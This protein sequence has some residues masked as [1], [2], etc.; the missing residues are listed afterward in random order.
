MRISCRVLCSL[1]LCASYPL[2]SKAQATRTVQTAGLEVTVTSAGA[3]TIRSKTSDLRLE[4]QL[5][6]A[7]SSIRED[8]GTDSIGA[9]REIEAAYGTAGR[10]AVVRLYESG[11]SALLLDEHHG[12]DPNNAPFPAF[13]TEPQDLMR[14]GY[15]VFRFAPIEFGELGSMGPWL[16]FDHQRNIMV[17]SP[18]DN[19]L[20]SSLTPDANGA[21]QSGIDTQIA[22]LPQGFRHGT[23]VTFGAGINKTLDAWGEDL[24]KLGHKQPVSNDADVVLEKFGYWTDNGANYYYKFD[25]KLGYEGT[26]LAVRDQ[27]R[28]LGVPLAYMQLDSWWYPKA[29]GDNPNGDNGEM[30]Y[31]ADPTIFPDGLQAFHEKMGLPFA[32]HARWISPESPY[33]K[34]YR[35]SKNVSIDPRFWSAIAGYLNKS[36][37]VIYEQDWLDHNAR[38]AIDIAQ[39]HDFLSMMASAMASKGIGIQ[40]CMAL[41]GYFLASTQFQNVRTIRSSDDH[42]IRARWD[43]FLY[44]SELAHAVGLWPW[45]DVFMSNELPNLVL[46]TLSAGPVGTGDALGTIDAANL[47][48][49]MRSDS[50]LLKPDVPLVPIDAMYLADADADQNAAKA[51][52]VAETQTSFGTATEHYVFSYPRCSVTSA[53]LLTARLCR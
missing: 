29:K 40:Y 39:S 34:Q 36:G 9:Y 51:P 1:F 44:T 26:L 50:V 28:K 8:T 46:S 16:F 45:S 43:W 49:A 10:V 18:A 12:A 52:M 53:A 5:P 27:F 2:A 38:P 13:Q 19:F 14:A 6:S 4:G 37:V 41:P 35:I 24:Q 7:P 30:V 23:M 21:M 20:V 3:Y 11:S 47:K 48:R 22:T 32:T 33:R 42:F 15:R 25:P 17:I 31:Q